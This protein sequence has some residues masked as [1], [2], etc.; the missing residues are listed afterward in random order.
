MQEVQRQQYAVLNSNT[1]CRF[2]LKD[3]PSA[4]DLRG[5]GLTKAMR[6]LDGL[7]KH[8]AT[9]EEGEMLGAGGRL[10]VQVTSNG[11]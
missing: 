1:S 8:N 7:R 6:V 10:D 2:V 9:E 3:R 11:G 5:M 4:D